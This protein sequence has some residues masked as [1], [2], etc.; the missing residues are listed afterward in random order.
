MEDIKWPSLKDRN[1]NHKNSKQINESV[2]RGESPQSTQCVNPLQLWV[3]FHLK[4]DTLHII[5][6]S[7]CIPTKL[8]DLKGCLATRVIEIGQY[9]VTNLFHI[10]AH[11]RGRS[12]E[13]EKGF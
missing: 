13:I 5:A 3:L 10:C 1:V 12:A 8:A 6:I 7:I 2:F 11:N 9:F 4:L